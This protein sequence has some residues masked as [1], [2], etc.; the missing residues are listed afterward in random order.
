MKNFELPLGLE[1]FRSQFEATV[2]PYIEI[3]THVTREVNPW[4][5]KFAGFPYLP[6]NFDYPKTP[7]GEYLYLLAQINFEEVPHLEGFP[8]KGILQFYI[9]EPGEFYG[10]D[11]DKP[12]IQEGFRVLYF[13]EPDFNENNLLT[14]FSFLPTLWHRNYS[15]FGSYS[16]YTP[17]RKD[18]FALTFKLNSSP[19][20]PEDF[21]FNQ[22]IK[23]EIEE[24]LKENNFLLWNEYHNQF[25]LGHRLGGYPE[26]IQSDPRENLPEEADPYILLLQIDSDDSGTDKIYIHWGDGGICNFFI[27]ESALR[28][29]DFSSVLYNWDCA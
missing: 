20:T 4:Q 10:C 5:S 28:N 26:F 13:P 14:D 22:L 2:K 11:W 21:N 29:L 15:P 12:T 6:K 23:G 25:E 19:I 16:S 24:V 8:N 27:K 3:Q 9:S 1:R 17:D 7:E 18:C